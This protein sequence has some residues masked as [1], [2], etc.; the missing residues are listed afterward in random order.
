MTLA[1]ARAALAETAAAAVSRGPPA[2]RA[3]WRQRVSF[4]YGQAG[5]S[6][7]GLTREEVERR[8]ARTCGPCPDGPAAVGR[9]F[10]IDVVGMIGKDRRMKE[11][12]AQGSMGKDTGGRTALAAPPPGSGPPERQKAA[13]RRVAAFFVSFV[14]VNGRKGAA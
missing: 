5:M 2:P 11:R 13:A 12:V 10:P 4:A 1:P 6:N 8:A 3:I 7:P 9:L 14:P